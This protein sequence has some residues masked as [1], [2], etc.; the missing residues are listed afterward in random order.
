MMAEAHELLPDSSPV[1][2]HPMLSGDIEL[3]GNRSYSTHHVKKDNQLG[4]E[5]LERE[6]DLV[7]SEEEFNVNVISPRK[8][9]YS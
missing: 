3:M 7:D 4:I 1:Q 8:K 2:S 6:E 9:L 5:E